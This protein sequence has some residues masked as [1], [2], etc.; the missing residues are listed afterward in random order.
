LAWPQNAA[1]R[2]T[3]K[4]VGA[5][6]FGGERVTIRSAWTALN[7]AL[8]VASTT[9]GVD[10]RLIIGH[11]A[12]DAEELPIVVGDDKEKGRTG[13]G[14]GHVANDSQVR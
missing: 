6:I 13:I 2:N 1:W 11:W 12:F 9:C 8:I 3:S 5:L 4:F 7:L 10:P 14:C